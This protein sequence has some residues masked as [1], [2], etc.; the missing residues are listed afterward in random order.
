MNGEVDIGA[1]QY[2]PPVVSE[3]SPD[4]ID[5]GTSSP[6]TVTVTGT[7]YTASSVVDWNGA[8]L[9]TTYVSAT[10]LLATIP[11][12]DFTSAGKDNITVTNPGTEGGTSSPATF[13][14]VGTSTPT[15]TPAPTPTPTPTPTPAPT[16]TPTP[17]P[18]PTPSPTSPPPLVTMIGVQEVLNKKHQV[19]KVVV[20]FS[21]PVNASEADETSIYR[22]ATLGKRGSFTAKNAGIIRIK[23]A[24]YASAG[25]TVTLTPKTPFSLAK[26]VQLMISGSGSSGLQD[27]DGRL[28]DGADNGQ[29]GSNAV[30][31][32]TKRTVTID[33]VELARTSGR[34]AVR[35]DRPK[36][37]V[38]H[39]APSDRFLVPTLP[40]GNIDPRRSASL[41][42]ASPAG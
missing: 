36:V 28:I 2:Q 37:A 22:L 3:I 7:A 12:S 40:R 25:D 24:V 30:A 16:P 5:A 42:R 13:Q 14:V 32:L 21:G 8:A 27:A 33:A 31:V 15:P 41:G 4:Q 17:T 26:S 20:T 19:T 11:A 23:K 38:K 35:T 34:T 29:A 18:A 10:E 6:L 1:Y 9:E 39:F